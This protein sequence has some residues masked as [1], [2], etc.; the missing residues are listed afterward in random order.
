M[1]LPWKNKKMSL[2]KSLS[3]LYNPLKFNILYFSVKLPTKIKKNCRSYLSSRQ[4]HL[5][6]PL[7]FGDNLDNNVATRSRRLSDTQSKITLIIVKKSRN[8]FNFTFKFNLDNKEY[9]SLSSGE[10][11]QICRVQV[12]VKNEKNLP[13]YLI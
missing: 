1:R 11:Q 3:S 2:W 6:C 10:S 5:K 9:Q 13:L 8:I 12:F 7:I 4:Q